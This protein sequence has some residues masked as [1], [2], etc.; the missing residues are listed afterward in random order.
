MNERNRYK[1][2]IRQNLDC[3]IL[4]QDTM[5]DKARLQEVINIVL[6]AVCS[7][8]PTMLSTGGITTLLDKG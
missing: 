2:I 1:E 6:D 4:C 8:A 3:D 5:L 7:I